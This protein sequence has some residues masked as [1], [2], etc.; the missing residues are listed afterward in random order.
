[1]EK[2]GPIET[3][4]TIITIW[5][6]KMTRFSC[7]LLWKLEKAHYNEILNDML[8]CNVK[9]AIAFKVS[10]CIVSFDKKRRVCIIPSGL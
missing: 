4:M 3:K 5:K 9:G 1:M 10:I 6:S 7:C 2:R 8:I